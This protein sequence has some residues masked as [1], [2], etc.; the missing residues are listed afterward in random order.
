MQVMIETLEDERVA[1]YRNL[2]DRELATQ[3]DRFI[4]EGKFITKRLLAS[5]FPVESVMIA[6]RR[7]AEFGPIVPDDVP[8]YIVPDPLVHEIVGYK[9][10]SGVLAVGRRKPPVSI[11]TV[12]QQCTAGK[13]DGPITL[14]V[15][16]ATRNAENL[17]ALFRIAAAFGVDAVILGSECT[18]P[19]W[20]RVIRVS[21]GTVFKLPLVYSD[22]LQ[23]DLTRLHDVW[24]VQ[25]FATVLDETAESLATVK[26]PPNPNRVALLLGPEDHGLSPRWIEAC[27]RRVTIPMHLGTDSLNVAVAAA[28]FLYHFTMEG[29]H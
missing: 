19:W 22:D 17:G 7:L 10:H 5:D 25:R 1:P 11:D 20:R 6:E 26:R 18:D 14:M 8:L 29:P 3:G 12:M 15:L 27:D 16:P 2:K 13:P 23:R 24:Q 4:A 28:V 21:M 9:F